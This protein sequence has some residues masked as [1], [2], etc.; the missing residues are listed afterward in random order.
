MFSTYL[1]ED[2]V[3]RVKRDLRGKRSNVTDELDFLE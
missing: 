3:V 1:A 2:F